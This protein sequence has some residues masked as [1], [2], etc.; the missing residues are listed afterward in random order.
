[1]QASGAGESG[2]DDLSKGAEWLRIRYGNQFGYEDNSAAEPNS[3]RRLED[4]KV[5]QEAKDLEEALLQ[6]KNLQNK[7][8]NQRIENQQKFFRFALV[9][10]GLPVALAALGFLVLVCR[11]T[12]GDVTY[13]AF[14]ASVVAEVI[15]LSY[16][17]G[18]YFFPNQKEE[19]GEMLT[20]I[21]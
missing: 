16:I 6:Q 13:A 2:K 20:S 9:I 10:I 5:E 1:M 7:E 12:A 21:R 3:L 17:L 19:A 15:G 8:L 4:V 18:N 14:F 11:G